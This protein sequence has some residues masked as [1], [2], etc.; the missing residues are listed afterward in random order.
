MS[1]EQVGEKADLRRV[2]PTADVAPAEVWRELNSTSRHGVEIRLLWN[3]KTQGLRVTTRE[4]N[5]GKTRIV[6]VPRPQLAGEYYA[7]PF[8]YNEDP[9]VNVNVTS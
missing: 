9:P 5:T 7:H 2:M 8:R 1:A 6:T 3:P 4:L